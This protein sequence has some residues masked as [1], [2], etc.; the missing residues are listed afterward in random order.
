MF[1]ISEFFKT[2]RQMQFMDTNEDLGKLEWLGDR[3]LHT[4]RHRW[5]LIAEGLADSLSEDTLATVLAKKLGQSQDLRED[6]AYYYRC[7]EGHGDH[8]YTYLRAAMDRSLARKQQ[9]KNRGDQT[10]E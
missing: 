3:D 4:F 8:P 7:I 1:I 5:S 6:I 9:T 2:N 10:R